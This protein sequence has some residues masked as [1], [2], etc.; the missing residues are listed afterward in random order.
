MSFPPAQDA[1]PHRPAG[2]PAH[3]P[4]PVAGP[5]DV[6]LGFRRSLGTHRPE[7]RVV[8][9][10]EVDVSTQRP[11]LLQRRPATAAGGI[12][13]V[14]AFPGELHAR[15]PVAPAVPTIHPT[16]DG[17][18]AEVAGLVGANLDEARPQQVAGLGIPQVHL[19][20]PPRTGHAHCRSSAS[21]SWDLDAPRRTRLPALARRLPGMPSA[22]GP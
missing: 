10:V 1:A 2:L 6:C 3:L 18:E 4:T 21:R 22:A 7:A 9:Q 16:L 17:D 15:A 19:H 20:D 13:L 8:T 12:A 11:V 5:P 14:V